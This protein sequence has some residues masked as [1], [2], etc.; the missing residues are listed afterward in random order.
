MNNRESIK[1]QPK[2]KTTAGRKLALNALIDQHPQGPAYRLKQILDETP[3]MALD[4]RPVQIS[5][6]MLL[7]KAMELSKYVITGDYLDFA[8]DGGLKDQ[9]E[10]SIKKDVLYNHQS[11]IIKAKNEMHQTTKE[12]DRRTIG[13]T[14]KDDS[15]SP[16]KHGGVSEEQ[17]LFPSYSYPPHQLISSLRQVF[18]V[19]ET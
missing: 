3:P 16:M 10:R 15:V 18:G 8:G 6:D 17:S 4:A 11:K 9:D 14:V 12:V 5:K 19:S 7:R 2:R 13:S 1:L